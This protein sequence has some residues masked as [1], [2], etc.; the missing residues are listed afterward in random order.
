M[1]AGKKD[2]KIGFS[3][4]GNERDKYIE[5]IC[6]EL[7]KKGY[8]KDDIFYDMWHSEKINGKYGDEALADIYRERCERVVVLLSESYKESCWT[9]AEW[10]AITEYIHSR[11]FR[12]LCLLRV[13][14]VQLG[15]FHGL[16]DSKTIAESIDHK[17]IT[18]TADFIHKWYQYSTERVNSLKDSVRPG[19]IYSITGEVV[20]Q[21]WYRYILDLYERAMHFINYYTEPDEYYED[22]HEW[23]IYQ[24]FRDG[25]R[26][27][28]RIDNPEEKDQIVEWFVIS[29]N[30]E[31]GN[32]ESGKDVF[33][34]KAESG[35]CTIFRNIPGDWDERIFSWP[36]GRYF[37]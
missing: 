14:G 25:V 9:K 33:V 29:E 16:N 3:F 11:N 7:L 12:K 18:E 21:E 37:Q 31:R 24:Y 26:I 1:G 32:D 5:P 27:R 34:I 20:K 36:A 17:S 15:E 8:S 10:G 6:N 19:Y 23:R 30:C 28:R 13:N 35:Q 4:S 2:F 22:F